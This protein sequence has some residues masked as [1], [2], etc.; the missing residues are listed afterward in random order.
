MLKYKELKL[1]EK[2]KANINYHYRLLDFSYCFRI[3]VIGV[4]NESN[5]GHV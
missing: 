3:Q 4:N 1:Y 2:S 5:N